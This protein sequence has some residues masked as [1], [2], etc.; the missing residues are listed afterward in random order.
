MPHKNNYRNFKL[1]A[2]LAF[3]SIALSSTA[4]A[5]PDLRDIAAGSVTL[6]EQEQT[7]TIHQSSDKAILNWNSFDISIDEHT[8]FNQP[9][10][11]AT[12]LNRVHDNDPSQ[13]LGRLSATGNI[14]L[15]NPLI[16]QLQG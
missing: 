11:G 14:I 1:L 15:I 7:L 6:E 2:P 4:L 10:S 16:H 5:N 13:I 8:H 3:T 9:G 12:A